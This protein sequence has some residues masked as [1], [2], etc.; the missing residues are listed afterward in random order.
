MSDHVVTLPDGTTLVALSRIN[1][2]E[3]DTLYWYE[4]ES[5]LTTPKRYHR[6]IQGRQIYGT[7]DGNGNGIQDVWMSPTTGTLASK[8]IVH[9]DAFTD[10]QTEHMIDEAGWSPLPSGAPRLQGDLDSDGIEDVIVALS[11]NGIYQIFIVYGDRVSPWKDRSNKHI[12]DR[13][14]FLPSP[15]CIAIGKLSG[16]TCFVLYQ[17]K[18]AYEGF[19]VSHY[20]QLWELNQEDLNNHADSIRVTMLHE[21][22]MTDTPV[23]GGVCLFGEDEWWLF[24]SPTFDP[25]GLSARF[26]VD[27]SEIFPQAYDAPWSTEAKAHFAQRRWKTDPLPVQID[28][29]RAFL[30]EWG[31]PRDANNQMALTLRLFRVVDITTVE[32]ELLGEMLLTKFNYVSGVYAASLVPD[33][34]GD[35]LEDILVGHTAADTANGKETDRNYVDLFLTTQRTSVSVMDSGEQE[36]EHDV[37][38]PCVW[39]GAEA[40]IYNALGEQV[41]VLPVQRNTLAPTDIE[42]LPMQ[43]LWGVVGDCVKRV[44]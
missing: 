18:G 13:K 24:R 32:L 16:R 19:P 20:W 11:G 26:T 3:K 27:T 7:W 12:G 38:H 42:A 15:K 21:R 25:T 14:D 41:A 39:S 40:L 33:I 36:T 8:R 4:V 6:Q 5:L 43:P 29:S 17:A 22:D 44:R 28:A 37:P 31:T 2:E 34:D 1:P 23:N 30:V 10:L 9:L 35:G